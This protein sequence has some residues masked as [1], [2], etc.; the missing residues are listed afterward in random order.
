MERRQKTGADAGVTL[1]AIPPSPIV[2]VLGT[3]LAQRTEAKAQHAQTNR[4]ANASRELAAIDQA[5]DTVVENTDADS[6]VHPDGGGQ[7]GTGRFRDESGAPPGD[8]STPPA[9]DAANASSG[10][11]VTA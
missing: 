10:L 8:E 7:G 9:E 5:M 11:D 3:P 1:S 4:A 2:S 6:R